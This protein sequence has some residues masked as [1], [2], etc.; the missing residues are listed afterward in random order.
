MLALTAAAQRR[1]AHAV[2]SSLESARSGRL[3]ATHE[4]A[5]FLFGV[6]KAQVSSMCIATAPHSFTCGAET[7]LSLFRQAAIEQN[8]RRQDKA[9]GA[10]ISKGNTAHAG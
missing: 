8:A 6:L 10:A 7:T 5:A 3:T 2:S 9:A 4:D 1:S